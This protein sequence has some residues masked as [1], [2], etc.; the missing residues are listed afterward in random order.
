MQYA[1][2]FSEIFESPIVAAREG[3]QKYLPYLIAHQEG[4]ILEFPERAKLT[5]SLFD[6]Q[7]SQF[8]SA[9]DKP[10]ESVAVIPIRGLMTREGSWWD[11]G[12][13]EYGEMMKAAFADDSIKAVVLR[14]NSVGGTVDSGFPLKAALQY[15]NKPVIGAVDSKAYSMGYYAISFADKIFAVDDMARVGSIGIMATLRNNDEAYKQMGIKFTEVYPPESS[16]KN[17]ASREALKGKTDLLISEE[18]SPWARHFQELVRTN[19][20]TL[21]EE[22]EGVIEGRTFF[23]YDSKPAGNGLIDGV[24]PFDEIVKY[25][26]SYD[27]NDKLTNF[28]NQ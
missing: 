2:F 10:A 27:R 26:A 7:S 1:G 3:L 24:M 11:Y 21:N 20:P 22:V 17:K 25:A 28:F 5:M 8:S 16:W 9:N 23:A 6:M 15:K 18:L 13:D 12:T 19:R 14:L 4:R